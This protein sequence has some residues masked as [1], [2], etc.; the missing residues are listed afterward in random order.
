MLAD[1]NDTAELDIVAMSYIDDAE[2]L[3]NL[4]RLCDWFIFPIQLFLL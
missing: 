1:Q 2:N 3:N 4:V